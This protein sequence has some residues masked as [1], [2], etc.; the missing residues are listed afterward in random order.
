V[1]GSSEELEPDQV[2]DPPP[3]RCCKQ[4]ATVTPRLRHFSKDQSRQTHGIGRAHWPCRSDVRLSNREPTVASCPRFL[5]HVQQVNKP[6]GS[7]CRQRRLEH[8][9][10]TQLRR[11]ETYGT[12]RR[13]PQA[14]RDPARCATTVRLVQ[15]AAVKADAALSNRNRRPKPRFMPADSEV[16]L[17]G[18][19]PACSSFAMTSEWHRN[20]IEMTS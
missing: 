20:D 13:K 7:M 17:I 11:T 2:Q 18:L 4:H 16:R 12:S 3:P 9:R 19:I 8:A 6:P 10:A 1:R 15:G 5:T 14:C